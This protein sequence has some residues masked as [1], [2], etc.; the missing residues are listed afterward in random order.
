MVSRLVLGCDSVG[1]LVVEELSARPGELQVLCRD[2]GRV[3]TLRGDGVRATVGDPASAAAVADAVERPDAV[4][5]VFVGADDPERSRAVLTAANETFPSA[6]VVAY[7]GY[8]AD[9]ETRAAIEAG[10]D[11]VVDHETVLAE[12]FVDAATGES[13]VRCRKLRSVLRDL[14]GRLA[15]VTHETPDPDAIA[16][17][18][19]L[20]SVAERFG[21]P[22]TPCY[23]GEVSHQE[24]RALVNLLDLE[25]RSLDG[26]D[27]SE[28][29]GFAL[30][31]HSRPGINDGL[32]EDLYPDIVIDHHPPRGPVE[33]RFADLR[34]DVGA[35]STML[36][37]YLTE[38]GMSLSETVATAL[39]YGIRVDT[40]DF[41]REVCRED[42]LA[43]GTLLPHVDLAVLEK[44][45]S[46]SVGP[47]TVDVLSRAIRRRDV[48]EGVLAS[49]V[50]TI[51]DK[52]ALAQAA[53]R[54]LSMEGIDTVLVYG[55]CEGTVYVSARSRADAIDLGETL[56]TAFGRIGT[57]GGHAGMA[58]AQIPLGIIEDVDA[59]GDDRLDDAVEG[60]VADRFFEAVADRPID[61]S[62]PLEAG[63]DTSD[64]LEDGRRPDGDS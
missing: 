56:R 40:D 27:L 30:V 32:P 62:V 44:V 16:S 17:A 61:L 13:A 53:D 25:L 15:V 42:L 6:T 12:R 23:Y 31:D 21:V 34:S 5:L 8:A 54:L 14:D 11:H 10:A 63:L 2:E 7:T 41:T 46:P 57:A 45:E 18:I 29:A 38:L 22:A 37:G 43:A 39:L 48:R 60:L 52:D 59:D 36:T 24:N 50:G 28:F 19:A 47:E 4:D 26:D 3:E 51:G 1:A 64:R 58:G 55:R 33:A 49:Y 20:A 35:T 9:P